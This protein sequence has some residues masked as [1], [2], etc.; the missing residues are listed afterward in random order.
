MQS[1]FFVYF[2]MQAEQF[3]SE[4]QFL[5]RYIKE[6]DKGQPSVTKQLSGN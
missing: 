4:F 6:R 5:A 3:L 2:C 1:F